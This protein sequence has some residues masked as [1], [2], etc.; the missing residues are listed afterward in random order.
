MADNTSIVVLSDHG[1][2]LGE[3]NHI[4]KQ[5]LW[6]R[7]TR[8]PLIIVPPKRLKDMPRGVRCDRPAELLDVYPT[9][10]AAAGLAPID[11]DQRLDGISLTPWLNKPT[12]EK[13]RPAIT[14]I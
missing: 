7:S 2:H 10:L 13:E 1:W 14:T 4:A 6:T 12:A 11:A 9:L 8:V 5:T 3:K